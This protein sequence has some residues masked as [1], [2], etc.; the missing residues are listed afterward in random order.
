MYKNVII[1]CCIMIKVLVFEFISRTKLYFC[2][3]QKLL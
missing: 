2:E 1:D 3:K